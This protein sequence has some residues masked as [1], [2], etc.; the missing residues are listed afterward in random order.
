LTKVLSKEVGASG[1]VFAEEISPGF[2]E[3][4]S[5][6]LHREKLENVTIVK[7]GIQ[8]VNLPSDASCDIALV[9]DVY[10]HFEY[11]ITTCR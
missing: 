10:H 3:L 9:C 5:D 2:L 1:K 6:L 4:L 8:N 7:G 11:P